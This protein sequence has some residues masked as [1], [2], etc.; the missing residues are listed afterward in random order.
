MVRSSLSSLGL[1][2][3][4]KMDRVSVNTDVFGGQQQGRAQE[5]PEQMKR[6]NCNERSEREKEDRNESLVADN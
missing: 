1:A 2:D 6:G 5:G 3:L 4:W